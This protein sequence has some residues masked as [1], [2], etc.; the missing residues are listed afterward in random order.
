MQLLNNSSHKVGLV[1]FG[2]EESDNWLH[3]ESAAL[4]DNPE[5]QHI[6]TQRELKSI[7]LEFLRS[8]QDIEAED[9]DQ[10]NSL[11][12][13]LKVGVDMLARYCKQQKWKKRLFLI[14]DGERESTDDIDKKDSLI[15]QISEDDVKLNCITIDFCNNIDDEDEE[16]AAE[17]VVESDG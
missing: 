9:M 13:A 6:R 16:D 15:A 7:D 14:T 5:Y 12:D 8:V 3:N 1:L 10:G 2:S 17:D 11:V 4:H